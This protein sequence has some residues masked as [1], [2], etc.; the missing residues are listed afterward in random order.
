MPQNQQ[1][2]HYTK[3]ENPTYTGIPDREAPWSDGEVLRLLEAMERYDDDWTEVAEYV[4]TRTKEECVVK[5]LQFEIEDKYLDSEPVETL[6]IGMLGPE[7]GH[8]PFSQA[9]NPVMSVIG[10]LAGLTEPS[11]TAAAANKTVEAMKQSLRDQLEKPKASEK[12]KERDTSD[13][14]EIDTRHEVTT[15][16]T[17]TTTTHSLN[18]LATVPLATV[19]ARSGGL[20]SHEEREMTRLVSATVNAE[21]QKMEMK[22][23]QFAEM[24]EILQA[25]RRELERGRQQLFLDRLAFKKR[26]KDVQEGLKAA[27]TTGGDE[28][29]RLAQGVMS[30][31]E[32][33]A[34]NGVT[35]AADGVQPLSANG[36][37]KSYDV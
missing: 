4:G 12:G 15:T 6:G 23:K 33:L 26:V 21:L 29:I 10:F 18:Q 31:S 32:R 35:P 34:F 16:T 30:G 1:Q 11:V 27:A 3:T 28:G 2:A 20:A 13:S 9:D 36:Q 5:F 24:E 8:L 14:M 19:A 25:E 37:I 7:G 17:T 22:L